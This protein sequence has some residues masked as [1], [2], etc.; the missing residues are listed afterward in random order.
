MK[1]LDSFIVEW[2][3]TDFGTNFSGG[4][5]GNLVLVF[6]SF[7]LTLLLA[8]CLGFEREYHGH[9]AG[10]R[11]HV[12]IALGACTIMVLSLYGFG[13][14]DSVNVANGIARDPARLAAQVVSGIGFL[15]AGTIIQTGMNIKG[16]TTATTLWVAM[17]IGLACGTGCF[18]VAGFVTALSFFVLIG[19][20]RIE[21]LAAKRNPAVVIVVPT[22]RPVLGTLLAMAKEYGL[23]VED[24]FSELT[25]FQGKTVLRLVLRCGRARPAIFSAYVDEI[26]ASMNPI[27]VHVNVPQVD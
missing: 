18:I 22:D 16:L 12:M 11:T 9:S 25:T 27:A 8:G 20:S 6:L 15:G 1:N 5:I 24:T 26:R 13:Y 21:I 19:M 17:A 2:F 23:Q 3:N 7:V 4:I 10:L 14:W